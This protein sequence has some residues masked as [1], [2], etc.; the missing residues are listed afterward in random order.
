MNTQRIY[1]ALEEI[2][3]KR[4]SSDIDLFP[5]IMTQI[6]NRKINLEKL[7]NSDS[8]RKA[9]FVISILMIAVLL[10]FLLSVPDVR[11][12]A[13]QFFQRFGL[14]LVEP[15]LE[16]RISSGT[17]STSEQPIPVEQELRRMN[18]EEAQ[19]LVPFPIPT[20]KLLPEGFVLQGVVVGP[21]P[22]GT[23]CDNAGN[24]TT[25]GSEIAV[26][27]LYKAESTS[28][29]TTD[30]SL[31]LTI[32]PGTLVE[33]S[34]I[35]VPN[36]EEQV[37]FVNGREA[38]YVKGGWILEDENFESSEE[39][40]LWEGLEWDNTTD[41]GLLSWEDDDF[42]YVLDFYNLGLEIDDLVE[43]AESLSK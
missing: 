28:E 25:V 37:I 32:Y 8:L 5:R 10:A 9:Y 20:L 27:L 26:N 23:S 31:Q 12:R 39:Q 42:T 29:E 36:T 3:E 14:V 7:P 11:A 33:G 16:D 24:C 15:E 22:Q 38:T 35:A 4:I 1:H 18:L 40:N 43:I 41:T 17:D 2:E 30:S 6:R 21:G 34:G 13:S 19:A